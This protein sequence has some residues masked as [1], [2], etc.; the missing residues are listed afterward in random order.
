RR[1]RRLV[2][3]ARVAVLRRPL[4]RLVGEI[5][6]LAKPQASFSSIP[7]SSPLGRGSRPRVRHLLQIGKRWA[8]L[9]QLCRR[10]TYV[11]PRVGKEDVRLESQPMTV[12]NLH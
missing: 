10:S 6:W 8:Y 4:S 11:V 12:G 5:E 3:G 7:A 2:Q 1:S 9:Q